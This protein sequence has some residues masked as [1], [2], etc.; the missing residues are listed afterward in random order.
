MCKTNHVKRTYQHTAS[1]PDP[2]W[3]MYIIT[4]FSHHT[5]IST[6]QQH[7]RVSP[8]LCLRRFGK[9]GSSSCLV[10]RAICVIAWSASCVYV[11]SLLFCRGAKMWGVSRLLSHRCRGHAVSQSLSRAATAVVGAKWVSEKIHRFSKNLQLHKRNYR[12]ILRLIY[13]AFVSRLL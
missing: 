10:L 2:L 13:V 9:G 4:A 1:Q 8:F 7:R 5:A 11:V 6:A 12:L 3:R